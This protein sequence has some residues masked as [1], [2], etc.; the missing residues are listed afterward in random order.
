[1]MKRAILFIAFVILVWAI[2]A[3]AKQDPKGLFKAIVKIRA[4]IPPDARTASFLGT[5]REGNGVVIDRQGH[6][7]TIGYLILEAE[8]IEVTGPKGK[9]V[10]ATSIAYDQE[11]GF[12]ILRAEEPFP[13]APMELGE[14]SAVE[15]GDPLLVAGYGGTE[16]VQGAR[17]I[18]RK[19]FAGYWEYLLEN[20]IF[21]AP[22]VP[23]FG[24]AALI[25]RQGRLVGI[26]S[27]L[28]QV[29]ISGLGTVAGNM[30]VPIDLIKPILADL[31]SKGRSAKVARP[32][33]GVNL[34]EAHGRVFVTRVSSGSPAEKAGLQVGDL[35][36]TVDKKEVK[37]LADFYRKVWALGEAGTKIP[38]GILRG[39]Q[40]RDLTVES[41]DRSQ[42]YRLKPQKRI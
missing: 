10:R 17:V 14:S 32:W 2:P 21:T 7:L 13:V 27:L 41:A 11:T 6:I 39:I 12:G 3:Y 15:E 8:S 16:A 23:N 29:R 37:G 24:G 34:E 18:S 36:L 1:M 42:F 25:D 19:E 35:L 20:P 30:F 31:I 9:T 28:T 5:E 33:L 40:I 4:T 38:L 26:G 22:A